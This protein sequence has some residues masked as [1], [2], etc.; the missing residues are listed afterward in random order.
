MYKTNMKS[1]LILSA[2]ALV[3]CVIMFFTYPT[4]EGY[5]RGLT[6]SFE[7]KS[8]MGATSSR[9]SG[10][11]SRPSRGSG[12][13]S[14]GSGVVSRGGAVSKEVVTRRQLIQQGGDPSGKGSK[15]GSNQVQDDDVM[16]E[17]GSDRGHPYINIVNKNINRNG[18]GYPNGY[19]PYPYYSSG[20]YT[21]V[22]Y[23]NS[24][25]P[26]GYYPYAY[27]LDNS[28]YDPVMNNSYYDPYGAGSS[29][30]TCVGAG[31][32]QYGGCRRGGG[33]G[34]YQYPGYQMQP[35]TL[36]YQPMSANA[37]FGPYVDVVGRQ[38]WIDYAGN[39]GF[40]NIS[41]RRDSVTSDH[42]IMG[43]IGQCSP[44]MQA[45]PPS[46]YLTYTTNSP[47]W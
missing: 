6:K 38:Q 39:N 3:F 30:N 15:G 1:L 16:E 19:Y 25:Y 9:V 24:Y 22:P 31:G 12:S 18:G 11:P 23:V 17:N 27:G 44:M 26:P 35:Q 41:L 43:Y 13:P 28:M 34:A 4:S 32:M 29:F 46:S 7:V 10:S 21:T 42:A 8:T 33:Y 2:I 37:A 5:A 36:C 14:R 40:T 45:P 20:W 47:Y